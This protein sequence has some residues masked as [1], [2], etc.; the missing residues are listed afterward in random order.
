MIHTT[1]ITIYESARLN[2]GHQPI[3]MKSTTQ[4]YKNLSTQLLIAPT[5]SKTYG[6]AFINGDPW[7]FRAKKIILTPTIT[8]TTHN[9]YTKNHGIGT[10]NALCGL[11]AY[12]NSIMRE[13]SW[14]KSSLT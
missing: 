10:L 5:I 1:A 2:T 9:M 4:P 8:T 7:V 6:N 14:Y 12:T 13:V 11:Q 3:D